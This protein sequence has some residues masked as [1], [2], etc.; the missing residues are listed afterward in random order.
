MAQ[1]SRLDAL[2][3]T[4]STAYVKTLKEVALSALKDTQSLT[5]K[6]RPDLKSDMKR[7]TCGHCSEHDL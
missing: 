6:Q 5:P 3:V 4:Q 1:I 7:V 2:P